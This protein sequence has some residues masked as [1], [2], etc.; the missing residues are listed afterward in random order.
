M[1][2]Y[3]MSMACVILLAV[4][5]FTGSVNAGA[6]IV[7]ASSDNNDRATVRAYDKKMQSVVKDIQNDSGYVRIPFDTK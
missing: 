1:N 5:S 6:E 2:R 7:I 3:S 4:I